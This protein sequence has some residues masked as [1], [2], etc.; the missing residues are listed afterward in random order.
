MT[1]GDTTGFLRCSRCGGYYA[2][3]FFRRRSDQQQ[4]VTRRGAH[5]FVCIGCELTARTEAKRRDRP[6]EKAKRS[7]DAHADK[8]VSAGLIAN[9]AELATVY[10]WAVDRMAH[11]IR[12]VYENT[13][14]YCWQPFADMEHGLGDVSLD[15]IDPEREPY[16]RTNV[17]WC[18]VTCNREKS[19]TPPDEWELKLTMWARWRRQTEGPWP[20]N[21]LFGDWDAA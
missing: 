10:G 17:R 7:Y 20:P 3:V 13:C 4:M 21:S 12:H 18:C 19:K 1:D 9:R 14:P 8:F 16:Y 2:P 15:V 5:H 11:D 6:R